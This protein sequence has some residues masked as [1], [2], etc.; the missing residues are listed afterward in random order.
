[1]KICNFGSINIDHVYHVDH[2]VRPG[3]TLGSTSY[4]IF[5][6]GKGFNQSIALAR[7][8]A[9]VY[10]AGMIGADGRWLKERLSREGVNV[11]HVAVTE[12]EP[13]GHAVIQVAPDGENAI[14]L[15]GGANHQVREKQINAVIDRFDTGDRLLVQNEIT[16]T[17]GIIRAAKE[18]GLFV[19]LNPAP[20]TE[21]ILDWPL[22]RVDLF[23]MNEIEGKT[24]AGADDIDD[25]IPR[26]HNTFPKASLVLTLG[27]RGVIHADPSGEVI[28]TPA[29]DV[30]PIDTTGAGDTFIG[31][32]LG[33]WLTGMPVSE[34]LAV[35]CRA[36]A[37]CIGRPGAAD[38]IPTKDEVL[39]EHPRP[40]T[41]T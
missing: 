4:Q 12:N 2:F 25:V 18:R 40:L 16:H 13:T 1:M 27:G 3:E 10:H 28:S 37:L 21:D 33:S 41:D 31:F 22:E 5:P 30:T 39:R 20:V 24:L 6:G 36:A 34:A 26:L 32:F 19:V 15:Y 23:I 17:D 9:D 14:F 7:A 29:L 38:S 8:G 35:G 11:D